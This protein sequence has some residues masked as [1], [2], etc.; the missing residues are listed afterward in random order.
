MNA[1]HSGQEERAEFQT[2]GIT[3]GQSEVEKGLSAF[4]ELKKSQ[5]V[6]YLYMHLSYW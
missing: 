6:L 2:E 4:Q 5:C 1:S 3:F